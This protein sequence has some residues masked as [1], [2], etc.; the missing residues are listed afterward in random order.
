MKFILS[1][2]AMTFVATSVRAALPGNEAEGRRLHDASCTGCHD[3]GVY[4]RKDHR[5]LS[6]GGL[7]HQV[8]NCTHMAQKEFSPA[9]KQDIL[10]Y[11]NDEFY[12]FGPE[13]NQ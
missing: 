9:E 2:I 11:L 13:G 8:D 4:T 7:K 6:L 3:T 1:L 5:V 10:K 12:H